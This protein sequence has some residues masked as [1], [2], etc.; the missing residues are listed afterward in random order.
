MKIGIQTWGTNGDVRPFLAL[1]DGLRKAGHEVTL[2]VT[3]VDN[4][5]YRDSCERMGIAYRQ[6]PGSLGFDLEDFVRR[7][8][9]M[10][11]FQ[12][13]EALFN[14]AFLPYE[15]AIYQAAQSLVAENDYV[16]G[17]HILYPLKLAARR[18]NKAFFSV[19][20][21]PAAIPTAFAAPFGFPDFGRH[22][23]PIVWK[24]SDLVFN[25]LYKKT[26]TQ[27]WREEGHIPPNSVLTGLL[28]SQRLNLVAVDPL[29]CSGS[30]D[31]QPMHQA[32][33]FL[34]LAES[35]ENW[36]LPDSLRAF[37]DRGDPP[38]YMTFGSFQQSRPDWSLNLFMQVIELAGCRAIVQTDSSEL[39]GTQNDNVYFIGKHPHQ[40]VFEHCAAVVHHG[41]AGTTHAATR[42]GCPSVVIPFM[43][44]QFVWGR[45]L[46]RLKLA[47]KPLPAKTVT[48]KALAGAVGKLF[49]S[50]DYRSRAKWASRSMQA[51]DGVSKAIE[52]LHSHI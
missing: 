46:Q 18:Q 8:F 41:G 2:I 34:N 24:V 40:P 35:A 22:I 32:C 3:S 12:W 37:L 39:F 5:C 13:L 49:A 45:R 16:I 17:R 27:L 11:A 15:Q 29:F 52:L 47:G 20:F 14:E 26:L 48:A 51:N 21:G 4:R 36:E 43:D 33:G 9:R 30:E 19:T 50:N 31:W 25:S 7:S 6:V 42:S 38:I 28:T 44:E 10:N 23:N 1:G